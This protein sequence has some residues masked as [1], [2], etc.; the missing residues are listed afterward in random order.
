MDEWIKVICSDCNAK[1]KIQL[2]HTGKRG[3]CPKC[4]IRFVIPKKEEDSD[5]FD[6]LKDLDEIDKNI[7]RI[8][9][10]TEEEGSAVFDL[11]KDLDEIDKKIKFKE[12]RKS[13]SSAQVIN[14]GW[15]T[16]TNINI[17]NI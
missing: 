12:K 7:D 6:L 11:L 2:K 8:D 14:N 13:S 5:V 9:K 16:G 15:D 17:D 3:K 4:H 10:K 1:L